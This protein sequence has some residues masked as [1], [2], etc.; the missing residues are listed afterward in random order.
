MDSLASAVVLAV[1]FVEEA[2]R[3]AKAPMQVV[4]AVTVATAQVCLRVLKV[5][6]LYFRLLGNRWH[7][8][9]HT[10]LKVRRDLMRNRWRR[11]NG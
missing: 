8:V 2:V 9:R 7:F 1:P 5:Y 6:N 4:R 10:A 3:V 11:Q